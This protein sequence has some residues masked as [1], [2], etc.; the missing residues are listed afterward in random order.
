MADQKDN[1][2]PLDLTKTSSKDDYAVSHCNFESF[3]SIEPLYEKENP[4]LETIESIRKTGGD[5]SWLK[6][7]FPTIEILHS[8][9]FAPLQ[10]YGMINNAPFY[11][12]ERHDKAYLYLE[13]PGSITYL[14]EEWQASVDVPAERTYNFVEN[15]LELVKIV[16][17]NA[18]SNNPLIE[19]ISYDESKLHLIE[20][21]IFFIECD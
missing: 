9:G 3:L 1:H 13:E 5:H 20:T 15:F 14:L 16:N 7:I 12:R 6:E 10:V 11:Y 18:L 4:P 8:E 21:E 19:L 2:T 17:E